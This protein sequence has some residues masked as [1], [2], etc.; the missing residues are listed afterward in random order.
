[1]NCVLVLTPGD[2]TINIATRS[3]TRFVVV[4]VLS[5]LV[6]PPN[7]VGVALTTHK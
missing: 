6:P 2:S 5:V 4:L 1:L 7:P 3:T